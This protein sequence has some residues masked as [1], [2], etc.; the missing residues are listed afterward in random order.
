MALPHPVRSVL[1]SVPRQNERM[2]FGPDAMSLIVDRS[3]VE[4]DCWTRV[5]RRSAGW[6]STAERMPELAPAAKWTGGCRQ[7]EFTV[8]AGLIGFVLEE[9]RELTRR[10]RRARFCAI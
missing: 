2:G 5:F 3:V 4:C 6:R 1:G 7:Y 9:L 10:R 8:T